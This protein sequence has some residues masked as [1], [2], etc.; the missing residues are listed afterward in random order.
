VLSKTASN[1]KITKGAVMP[2][3]FLMPTKV[4]YGKDVV[5]KNRELLR[6]LGENFL[7][8]TGKSSRKN[9]G[10]EDVMDALEGRHVHI[11]DQTPENP[12]LELVPQICSM[13]SNSEIDVIIGLGGGSPMDTAK[14]VAVLLMNPQLDAQ[15]LYDPTK[16][17][18]A[19]K[20]I[21]IPTTA[22]TGSEV[23]QF[24]V[25]TV[26][27]KKKGFSNQC[28]FPTLSLVDYKYTI[29]M[30]R[31]LT[32]STGLDALCHAIEGYISL[33]ATPFSDVLALESI[34]NIRDFLPKVV[35]DPENEYYRERLMFASTLAGMVI[36][37]TSTTV[38][39][40]LGY[41]LTT[42][43]GVKHGLATAVFLPFEL[44][45]AQT[46][47]ANEV[48]ALFDGSL[49][50][51]YDTI[52]LRLSVDISDEEISKWAQN[53]STAS[54]LKSTPGSYNFDKLVEALREVR[55]VFCEA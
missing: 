25:L 54:H 42:N 6:N 1:I 7:V 13:F 40:A 43:K 47:K 28:T 51:F 20:L 34:K 29:T 26:D 11:F 27:G 48:N 55:D 36:A 2:V 4:V 23:T 33:N 19:K 35:E 15:E 31:E 49:Y 18:T 32:V 38:A 22:G 44:R 14:A 5:L 17:D 12:P 3:S 45:H 52:G 46:S 39:H 8:I 9:G 10:L 21:C 41:N 50:R 30:G 24:S 37:Q 53:T 16:Y